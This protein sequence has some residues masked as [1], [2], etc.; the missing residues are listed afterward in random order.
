M[1]RASARVLREDDYRDTHAPPRL[2]LVEDEGA[3]TYA[4][5]GRRT[6]KITGQAVPPVGAKRATH[7]GSRRRSARASQIQAR[8][9]RIAL[10]A[11]LLGLF[12]VFMAI[13]TAHAAP[14]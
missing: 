14:T 7:A 5:N 13:A 3:P 2:H 4:D 9:D 11:F 10:W 8:P 6:V 12:L 1:S